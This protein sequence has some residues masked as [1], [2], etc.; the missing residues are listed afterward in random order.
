MAITL[1]SVALGVVS[2]SPR[3]LSFTLKTD[4]L[5]SSEDMLRLAIS[6]E[7]GGDGV[8]AMLIVHEDPFAITEQ[9]FVWLKSCAFVPVMLISLITRSDTPVFFTVI[10]LGADVLPIFTV[11]KFIAIGA[12]EILGGGVRPKS[13]TLTIGFLGSF[14]EILMVALFLPKGNVGVNVTVTAHKPFVGIGLGQPF[15]GL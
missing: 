14:E 4:F 10:V 2:L 1:L 7:V 5:G 11:A 13:F 6:L 3:P 15:V 8:K 12:A 9:L